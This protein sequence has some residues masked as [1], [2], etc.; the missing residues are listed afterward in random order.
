MEELVV[1]MV[2]PVPL[3]WQAVRRVLLEGGGGGEA[4]A[5]GGGSRK[6]SWQ[7]REAH[8][9]ST[10]VERVLDL[11]KPPLHTSGIHTKAEC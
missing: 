4:V 7:A 10:N 2:M 5:G 1:M 8:A 6:S 3:A 11:R 9:R